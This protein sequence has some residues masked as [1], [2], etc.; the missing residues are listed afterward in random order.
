[1]ENYFN[2]WKIAHPYNEDFRNSVI[3]FT[4]VDL[5]WFLINGYKQIN[6]LIIPLNLK[7]KVTFKKESLE[8]KCQ[9]ILLLLLT[10]AKN[11]T[12]TSQILVCKENR[13]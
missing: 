7:N 13:S 8:C 9:L 4:K 2:T 10:M 11:M 3:R 1:M 5:N 6:E 12:F